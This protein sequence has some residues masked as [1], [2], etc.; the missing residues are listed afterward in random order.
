MTAPPPTRYGPVGLVQRRSGFQSVGRPAGIAPP[1]TRFGPMGTVAQPLVSPIAR[2]FAVQC[3]TEGGDNALSDD[4]FTQARVSAGIEAA[5][6]ELKPSLSFFSTQDWDKIRDK[7]KVVFTHTL[8][9]VIY[10][11][12]T[13][14]R[15]WKKAARVERHAQA[16]AK[17]KILSGLTVLGTSF[18][19]D[20]TTYVYKEALVAAIVAKTQADPG[21]A[22]EAVRKIETSSGVS[23]NTDIKSIQS[24]ENLTNPQKQAVLKLRA[25]KHASSGMGGNGCAIFFEDSSNPIK[26]TVLGHHYQNNSKKYEVVWALTGYPEFKLQFPGG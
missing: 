11:T 25:G 12:G 14:K 7:S 23:S 26:V 5:I 2:G 8:H 10:Q 1:P 21:E 13:T 6:T 9:D 22:A 3:F 18:K 20:S 24:V 17:A 16:F 4:M 15:N 19:I